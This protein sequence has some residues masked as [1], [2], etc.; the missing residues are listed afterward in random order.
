MSEQFFVLMRADLLKT[1][2]MWAQ[3]QW[4]ERQ[5]VQ[6]QVVLQRL[7]KS[8]LRLFVDRINREEVT[9]EN[10]METS[11]VKADIGF[12]VNP[13][14]TAIILR[15][16]GKGKPVSRF[17]LKSRIAPEIEAIQSAL[18]SVLQD[19]FDETLFIE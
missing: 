4:P 5:H 14:E 12:Q 15:R 18:Q 16:R 6:D 17:E 10:C 9:P 1:D 8:L 19:E 13:N 3:V 7:R 11:R 2:E